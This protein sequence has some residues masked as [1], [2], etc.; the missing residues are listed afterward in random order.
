VN[1]THTQKIWWPQSVEFDL[2]DLSDLSPEARET[3]MWNTVRKDVAKPFYL[4][5]GPL[6]RLKLIRLDSQEHV[7]LIIL[8]HIIS[9][10]SSI[11]ILCRDLWAF[12]E[13]L[14]SGRGCD[15]P[16]LA[17]QYADFAEWQRRILKDGLM[18]DQIAYWKQQLAGPFAR[19]KVFFG[20]SDVD[21]LAFLTGRRSVAIKGELFGALK[22]LSQKKRSTMFVVVLTALKVLLCSYTRESDIR[23][24]TLVDHRNRP[25]TENLVGLFANT[26]I[27]RTRTSTDPTFEELTEQVRGITLAAYAHQDVPFE[28]VLQALQ[29]EQ[30]FD[31]GNLCRFMLIYQ[32]I[33]IPQFRIMDLNIEI[34]DGLRNLEGPDLVPT[35]FDLVFLLKERPGELE[36]CLMYKAVRFSE[37]EINSIVKHFVEIL[38]RILIQPQLPISK[39]CSF[40]DARS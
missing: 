31:P 11:A 36:G 16:P 4:D 7:L 37:A 30:T 6:Y 25:E 29:S 5:Q 27:I 21:E 39:I 13:A 17:V 35:S 8:H 23:I 32:T 3:E 26:V 40:S 2:L 14:C 28:A 20:R 9:D 24:A 1:G 12:Y 33:P 34:L 19:S 38:K 15:L 18:D 10:G 22:R